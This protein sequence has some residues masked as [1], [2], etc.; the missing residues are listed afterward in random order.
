MR[1]GGAYAKSRCCSAGGYGAKNPASSKQEFATTKATT[2]IAT[3]LCFNIWLAPAVRQRTTAGRQSGWP[4]SGTRK[5]AQRL[6]PWLES[7]VHRSLRGKMD[8]G[9]AIPQ[10]L[11]P[12]TIRSPAQPETI[13]ITKSADSRQP[14]VHGGAAG[15]H[16]QC[17]G[18]EQLSKTASSTLPPS[19]SECGETGSGTMPRQVRLQEQSGAARNHRQSS[20]EWWNHCPKTSLRP[21]ASRNGQR[22]SGKQ[23]PAPALERP[24]PAL[25][26]V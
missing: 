17:R 7:R 22:Q 1:V 4:Q 9:R 3:F 6:Q 20:K 13:Q 5:T 8:P 24:A 19:P 25:I 16:L 26:V 23:A 15:A 11:P 14:A 21:E 12:E 18:R 2:A 10:S